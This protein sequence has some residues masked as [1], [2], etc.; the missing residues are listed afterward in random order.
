[1]I[2]ITHLRINNI[3]IE[4][5]HKFICFIDN[6]IYYNLQWPKRKME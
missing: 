1:M 2:P 4:D 5:T 3:L 6:P